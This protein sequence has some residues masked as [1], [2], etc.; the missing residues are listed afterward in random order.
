MTDGIT[1]IKYDTSS[2]K[3]YIYCT[4]LIV[5]IIWYILKKLYP[6]PFIT[7]DSCLYINAASDNIDVDY[8][9]IGYS[10][11][12]HAV[13]LISH[14]VT[15]FVTL[16]CIFLQL[17]F[18]LFFLTIKSLFS[19]SKLA[20]LLLYS[21]LFLNPL[22]IFASNHIMS[23]IMFTAL[24]L[25]WIT[26]LLL[27]LSK[28]NPIFIITQAILILLTFTIR[29]TALYYPIITI[30]GF[31]LSSYS[32]KEKTIGIII[33]I[34]FLGAFIEFT[35]NKMES[36][37]GIKMYSYSSGW[38]NANNALYM[39]EN[40]ANNDSSTVP[41]K[42]KLLHQIT[43]SYFK[44]PHRKYN[45]FDFSDDIYSGCFYMFSSSSPLLKY[46]RLVN[47]ENSSAF[48]LKSSIRC[49]SLFN[50][51]GNYLIINHPIDYAKH[52][53]LPNMLSYYSPLSEIFGD[54]KILYSNWDD[55]GQ[56]IKDWYHLTNN[57]NSTNLLQMRGYLL[58]PFPIIISI[59]H[60]LFFLS[61]IF[62]I[63]NWKTVPKRKIR[64]ISIIIFYCVLNFLFYIL[65]TPS[66]LRFQLVSFILE[67]CTAICLFDSIKS[68]YLRDE[69]NSK[70]KSP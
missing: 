21:F 2:N 38:K 6:S 15:L 47:G 14:S 26:Q 9:P 67:I 46:D 57:K 22:F 40:I 65:L 12:I 30:I 20:S 27:I 28:P 4:I 29:Y 70:I 52:V 35:R 17:S 19:F 69:F 42:Y 58:S 68:I 59:I 24:S 62:L 31:S 55:L 1:N 18:L 34:I 50:S 54:V 49:S 60:F 41:G 3:I 33:T 13:G 36:T 63:I 39:Y 16:Q 45:L 56:K 61:L 51:Y 48:N 5:T 64:Y 10:K 8:W 32:I 66:V 53:I 43:K 25:L 7:F 37:S 23:D 11:F 44:A